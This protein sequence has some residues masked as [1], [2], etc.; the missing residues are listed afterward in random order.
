MSPVA[1]GSPWRGRHAL[2][3]LVVMAVMVVWRSVLVGRSYFNQ[4]DFY[5]SARGA[6]SELTWGYLFEPFAGH[7]IPAQQLNFWLVGTH[8]P[9]NWG[10]VAAEVVVLQLLATIVMWHLLSR[11]LPGRWVRV[12]LLAVFALSPLTLMPTLW[13]SAALALWPHVLCSLLA[14]LFLVRARQ[15]AGRTWVNLA[16][17]VGWCALG[18]AWHSRAVLI[19]PVLFGLAVALADEASGWR[20]LWAATRRFWYLWLV[21]VAG[22]VA[23][24][25]VRESVTTVSGGTDSVREALAIAW[26]YIGRNVVPGLLG[27]PWAA[28][29]RGGAVGPH[30][31]VTIVSLVLAA[32]VAGLLLWRGGPARRWALALLLAYVVA[33]LTLLVTGRGSFGRIIALDPRYAA[34]VLHV[35]VPAVAIAL[36]GAAPGFGFAW[37]DTR[38]R[39]R[40]TLVLGLGT[41]AYVVGACFGTAVL[42]PHFQNTEDRSFV[43]NLRADLAADPNQVVR[44]ELIPPELVLPLVGEDATLSSVFASLPESPAFDE[45]SSRLRVVG[46]DGRLRRLDLAGSIPSKPGRAEGCGYA[47]GRATKRVPF[48][49][50]IRGR[51]VVRL[52]YFTNGEST[53]EVSAGDW[54]TTFLARP[55]PNEVWIP[56]PDQGEEVEELRLRATGPWTVCVPSLEAG[57]P[58]TP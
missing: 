25:V 56:L 23:Y 9:F 26:Q 32:A 44:D 49:V 45:P 28:D 13:W 47:V 37:A 10:V 51:L 5:L 54:S 20:R 48:L 19:V 34:D 14:M 55:G 35:A 16:A 24:F 29:L 40:R 46:D 18:L 38:W 2:A 12:P 6:R 58:E 39:R 57:L 50:G 30:L 1:A 27:G 42:V 11:L 33:D 15:D 43:A 53:V 17:V 41:A 31:W 3:A 22:L 36:R 52:S 21:L 4:D 7:I 8:A